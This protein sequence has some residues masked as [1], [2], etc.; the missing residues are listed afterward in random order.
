MCC[1]VGISRTSKRRPNHLGSP[2]S[3]QHSRAHRQEAMGQ[4]GQEPSS[5]QE[6]ILAP[7]ASTGSRQPSASGAEDPRIPRRLRWPAALSGSTHSLGSSGRRPGR[8]AGDTRPANLAALTS[9]TWQYVPRRGR[10]E[11]FGMTGLGCSTRSNGAGVPSSGEAAVE[12]SRRSQR[13]ALGHIAVRTRTQAGLL[14]R[15][16]RAT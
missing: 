5:R 3:C 13:R 8:Q 9:P 2:S 1:G 7:S 4:A 15:F 16:A 10:M 11:G 6:L 12:F 14:D